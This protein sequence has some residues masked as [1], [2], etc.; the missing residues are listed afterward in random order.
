MTFIKL[1]IY[2]LIS[3]HTYML[4]FLLASCATPAMAQEVVN[5]AKAGSGIYEAI[6]NNNDGF[7]YVTGVGTRHAPNGALYKID[8]N[9]LAIVDTISLQENPPYGIAIN[10]KTNIAYTSNT[11]TNSVSAIDLASGKL[12]ATIK[13][14][15][16]NS[17]TREIIVDEDRNLIYVSDVGEPSRI[18]I[19]DGK[20]HSFLG[21]IEGLGK[22]ATGMCFLGNKDYIYLT[23]MGENAIY[24]VN[25]QSKT[26]EMQFSSAGE[27]PV[28]ITTDGKQL[29]V[30]NQKS[31]TITVLSPDG[32]L[33][34]SIPTGNG[35]IGIAYD[36]IK[37]L[38]Y[39]ANRQSGSTTVIDAESFEVLADLKTGSHPNHVKIHPKTGEAY[40]LNKQKGGRQATNQTAVADP[41][42]DTITKI[43]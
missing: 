6:I 39:S 43:K 10:Q 26:V 4:S 19:I 3:K 5:T 38:I 16:K 32:A 11:R 42:G 34:K 7:I 17:H 13:N 35:A 37:K 29:F 1:N 31:G 21:H 15:D 2:S 18:W 25:T 12:I 22:T 28:N 36:P 27:S 23:V 24:K 41:Q 8:G 20:T 40:V 14:G 30:A 9:S 33:L